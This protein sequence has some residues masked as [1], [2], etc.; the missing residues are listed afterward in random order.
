MRPGVDGT[1]RGATAAGFG[2]TGAG[3]GAGFGGGGA[4]T[5]TGGGDGA[6]VAVGLGDGEGD[7]EG[8]GDADG[9]ALDV[10]EGGG[11]AAAV[12]LTGGLPGSDCA[13]A[14]ITNVP[15]TDTTTPDARIACVRGVRRRMRARTDEGL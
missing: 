2:A 15:I 6:A 3:L 12:S 7:G 13:R 10:T 1:D 14:I 5:T 8:E 11:E 4:A 9:E